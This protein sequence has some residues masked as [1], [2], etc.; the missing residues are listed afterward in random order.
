MT[1]QAFSFKVT[2]PA[3][4]ESANV[5]AVVATHAV[6][7]SNLDA[8]KRAGFVERARAA[9]AQALK[10][11]DGKHCAIVFAA[12]NGQLTVTVGGQTVS[13]SLPA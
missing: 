11:A 8:G 10:S 5:V 2:V 6:E 7:Y 1:P 3:D 13:E 9:V 4:P 12:A